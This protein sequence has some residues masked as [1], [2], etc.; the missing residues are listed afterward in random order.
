MSVWEERITISNDGSLAG[1]NERFRLEHFY[2]RF[3][4]RAW[5]DL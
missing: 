2:G 3:T 1:L 4:E 5:R